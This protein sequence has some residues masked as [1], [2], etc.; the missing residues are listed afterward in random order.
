MNELQMSISTEIQQLENVLNDY[1]YH[2]RVLDKSLVSDQTFDELMNKLKQLSLKYP[3]HVSDNSPLK[4]IGTVLVDG[5]KKITHRKLMGSI[6]N[7][8]TTNEVRAWASKLGLGSDVIYRLD[9]KYDGISGSLHYNKTLEKAGTRGNGVEGD[10]ITD[11]AKMVWN[12]PISLNLVGE[13]RGEFVIYKRDFEK[14]NEK[15]EE[16]DKYKNP[17][18]LVSGTMKSSK[19]QII[20]D[21]FVH[22]IPFQALDINGEEIDFDLSCFKYIENQTKFV[23][24]IEAIIKE[25]AKIENN[26]TYKT[27]DYMVDGLVI[28][29]QDLA[30]RKQLGHGTKCPK[31]CL[32]YKFKQETA[33]T[34][35][36]DVIWQVG[37]ERITPVAI[38][39]PVD[40]GGST[41][42][43]A[44]LHNLSKM[45]ELKIQIGDTVEIEKA[46]FI[47][48]QIN[49]VIL[50]SASSKPIIP[51]EHCPVCKTK[52]II[53]VTESKF[54]ICPNPDCKGKRYVFIE[55][56]VKAL[57]IDD[58]GCKLV[59]ELVDKE[60]VVKY[61][62]LFA[63]TFD[64]LLTCERMGKKSANKI[65]KNIEN[66][67][68]QK[69]ADI[70]RSLGMKLIGRSSSKK[71]AK[72]CETFDDFLALPASS[73]YNIEDLGEE[74]TKSIVTYREANQQLLLELK[75][76]FSLKKKETTTN[77]LKGLT[78][79]I[80][81]KATEGR[82]IIAKAIEGKGGK[83]S[84]SVSAKVDYLILGSLEEINFTSSKTKKANKLN[85]TIENEF[86]VL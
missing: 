79:V 57:D 45:E 15:L 1:E 77:E 2:Y 10:D 39:E 43:R 21:R 34:V 83:I 49:K 72:I 74:S 33:I 41:I 40:L 85:V 9:D 32:A 11:N 6:D 84:S 55:N 36:N 3:E 56:F 82:A 18:N 65:L 5:F 16:K 50:Q 8:Y 24:N 35:T 54:L 47:I 42:S 38:L 67:K 12:I 80:T 19:S 13:I 46:G 22:F 44:T 86:F 27:K 7:A 26:E 61:P 37:K 4:K 63:L 25:I 30:F 60:L 31:W 70:I 58:V 68:T 17:R 53:E 69:L 29:V 52:T 71:I 73:I 20:R 76:I 64:Q 59:Q 14:I 28:K 78:F 51:P 66:A 62:D 48:P 75:E 81:G 23:G